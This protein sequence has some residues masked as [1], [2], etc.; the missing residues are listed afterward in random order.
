M[1]RDRLMMRVALIG[2]ALDDDPDMGLFAIDNGEV[3]KV[4]LHQSTLIVITEIKQYFLRP[5]LSFQG[6]SVRY[7]K[8]EASKGKEH[9]H[10]AIEIELLGD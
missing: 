3:T 8:V 5:K 2:Y 1:I 9:Y 7:D 6:R 4:F 10:H